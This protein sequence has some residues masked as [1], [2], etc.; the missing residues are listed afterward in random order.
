VV[1]GRGHLDHFALNVPDEA[2]FQRL[3]RVLHRC[4]A[5]DGTVTDFGSVKTVSFTDPDGCQAEIALW[6]DA[7]LR[8]FDQRGIECLDE[9]SV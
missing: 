4:G 8:T 1:F 9:V 2:T 6:V 7:P 5:S 3:R